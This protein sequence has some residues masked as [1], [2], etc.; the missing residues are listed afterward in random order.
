MTLL[1]YNLQLTSMLINVMKIVKNLIR[2]H[3]SFVFFCE[4]GNVSDCYL[5][6]LEII[7]HSCFTTLNLRWNEYKIY[8]HQ[9]INC[10]DHEF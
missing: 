3:L 5:T 1:V 6:N 8:Y 10:K 9:A 2:V 7:F 4:F